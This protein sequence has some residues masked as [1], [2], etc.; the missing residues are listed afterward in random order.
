MRPIG[1]R[2]LKSAVDSL[3]PWLTDSRVVDLYAGQGRFG[4]ATLEEG[5][6]SVTFVEKDPGMAREIRKATAREETRAA[7]QTRDALEF[8]EQTDQKFEILFADPPFAAWSENFSRRLFD[9]IARCSAKGAIFLV[10]H[11]SRVLPSLAFHGYSHWKTSPFG[12]SQLIYFRY[13]EPTA[14]S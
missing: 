8:L 10:K 11:P 13:A 12:E 14:Q 7:V 3:R 4:R 2:A 6:A 5:V 1:A 9:G